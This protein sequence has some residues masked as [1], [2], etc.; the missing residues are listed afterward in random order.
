MKKLLTLTLILAFALASIFALGACNTNDTPNDN[1]QGDNGTN[2]DDE[3]C[4]KHF[5]LDGDYECDGC[6]ALL[7]PEDDISTVT[8]TL[9]GE[10]DATYAGATVVAISDNGEF[11]AVAN[12]NGVATLAL[13]YGSYTFVVSDGLPEN[14]YADLYSNVID[15]K[16]EAIT[17]TIIDN[18][19]D[20]SEAKPFHVIESGESFNVAAGGKL[21]MTMRVANVTVTVKGEGLKLTVTSDNTEY[22]SEGG[23]ITLKISDHADLENT[24]AAFSFTVE[25]DAAASFTVEFVYPLGS[26]EN[27][28]NATLGNT[29]ASIPL[30]STVYY[31]LTAEADGILRVSSDD[32]LGKIMLYNLISYANEVLEG[33]GYVYV[34]VA[35][36]DEISVAVESLGKE[37]ING[38]S[39]VLEHFA[40]TE[41]NPFPAGE[42]EVRLSLDGGESAYIKATAALSLTVEGTGVTVMKNGTEVTIGGV[43]ELSENDVITVTASADGT[44]V[45]LI[46]E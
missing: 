1:N 38:V 44:A 7:E 22:V 17:L 28:I 34:T 4:T 5:D 14:H 9:V 12:E 19:P 23:E 26:Y 6:G 3:P 11:A 33:A 35:A 41:A 27:P 42:G 21:Y 32:A 30:E 37:E 43:I 18:T 13:A 15:E 36:G 45:K 25:A 46:F 40:C 39:F 29:D 10:G 24:F 16:T 31:K 2:N 8:V 20:G